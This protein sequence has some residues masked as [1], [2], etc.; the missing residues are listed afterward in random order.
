MAN[1]ANELDKYTSYTYH[2]AL[3]CHSSLTAIESITS[4]PTVETERYSGVDDNGAT[5]LINTVKDAHQIIDDV[6]FAYINSFVNMGT[7]LVPAGELSMNIVE[8]GDC[9]FLQKLKSAMDKHQVSKPSFIVFGLLVHFVGRTTDNDIESFS[10]PIIPMALADMKANFDHRGGNYGMKFIMMC[11]MGSTSNPSLAHAM[12]V[13]RIPATITF[14]AKTVGEA[15]SNLVDGL[16]K[17]Y[18]RT[19]VNEDQANGRKL[20]YSIDP[21]EY[22]GKKLRNTSADNSSADTAYHFSFSEGVPISDAI[23]KIL[24]SSSEINNAVGEA[25]PNFKKQLHAGAKI[26]TILPQYKPNDGEVLL[27]YQIKKYDGDDNEKYEFDFY[28]SD[29]PNVDVI[30]YDVSFSQMTLAYLGSN[31]DFGVAGHRRDAVEAK[32]ESHA[33][34]GDRI[35]KNEKQ[36]QE[37]VI[38]NPTTVDASPNDVIVPQSS[39]NEAM[40]GYSTVQPADVPAKKAALIAMAKAMSADY[41]QKTLRIRGMPQ[42]LKSCVG[43]SGI[44]PFGV[45]KGLWAKV[46]VF[47]RTFIDG[48]PGPKIPYFYQGYYHIISIQ[49]NFKDGKFEQELTL[50]MVFD[51][52]AQEEA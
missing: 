30:S 4:F 32:A 29:T 12:A 3:Y 39:P 31:L 21:G 28:F 23:T 51:N 38:P 1:P 22:G 8:P 49:S 47:T 42:L 14:M 36:D 18:D 17:N 7:P 24:M 11:T 40:R 46:N 41:A 48:E 34:A 10:M 50:V 13:S 52:V 27:D 26:F 25:G 37:H 2:F 43:Q 9:M 35:S 5:L 16:Q 33:E 44:I 15:L 6:N 45:T 20:K 19:K